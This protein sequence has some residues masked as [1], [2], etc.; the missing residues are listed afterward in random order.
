M[1]LLGSEFLIIMKEI[2]NGKHSIEFTFC[3]WFSHW[4]TE[5][6][7]HVASFSFIG[8]GTYHLIEPVR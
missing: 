4:L 7:F 1:N 8:E 5:F 6:V 2:E 3:Y